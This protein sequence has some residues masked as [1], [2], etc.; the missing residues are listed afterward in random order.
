MKRN[1]GG[2]TETHAVV[3][4]SRSYEPPQLVLVGE[5]RHVVFGLPGGGYD[6]PYG[7]TDP[8]FEFEDDSA[9]R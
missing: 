3:H 8:H 6:G 2:S 7:M 1:E 4:A 5:A 9:P